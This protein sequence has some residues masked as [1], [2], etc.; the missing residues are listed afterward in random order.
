MAEFKNQDDSA[1]M[2]KKPPPMHHREYF[3]LLVTHANLCLLTF[4]ILSDTRHFAACRFYF[5]KSE[6]SLC[7]PVRFEAAY[8]KQFLWTFFSVWQ[9]PPYS[10]Y[11]ELMNVAS[12]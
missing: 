3:F 2:Y 10:K 4:Q 7:Y 12:D 1:H 8:D 6:L 11:T 5:G 9:L